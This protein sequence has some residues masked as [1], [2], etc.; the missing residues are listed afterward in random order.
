MTRSPLQRIADLPGPLELDAA[1]AAR[2]AGEVEAAAQ[3]V[4]DRPLADDTVHDALDEV[5]ASLE[6]ADHEVQRN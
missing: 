6:A 2:A 3:A 5:E 4:Q 1:P